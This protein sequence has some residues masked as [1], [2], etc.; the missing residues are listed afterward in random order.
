MNRHDH[1]RTKTEPAQ[2]TLQDRVIS[3]YSNSYSIAEEEAEYI[4]TDRNNNQKEF[5]QI[6]SI[7][8]ENKPN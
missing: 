5:L 7:F 4:L 3:K 6:E 8:N 1:K 2:S